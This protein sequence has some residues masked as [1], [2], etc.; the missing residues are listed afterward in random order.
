MS[1]IYVI[2]W[3]STGNTEE[4]AN[5]IAQGINEAG[6]EAEV[7]HVSNATP[8]MVADASAVALGC[9]AMGAETLDEGEFEPYITSIEGFVS[10]KTLGLFGSYGWGD[11]Q[12]MRDFCDR[13]SAA[14]A[15]IATGEG[16]I[17]NEAP[18]DGAIAECIALGKE[19]ANA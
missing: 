9:S 14:G 7:V 10:G 16:V 5:A 13:M 1:K 8:D 12:W 6:K 17:A 3:S 15:T 19:L 11:G 18:D 4:M 2:Y